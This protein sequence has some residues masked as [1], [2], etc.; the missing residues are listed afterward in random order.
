M[1]MNCFSNFDL[2]YE[3][4]VSG[5]YRKPIR[6]KLGLSFYECRQIQMSN[7]DREIIQRVLDG[8]VR[9]F[10]ILVDEH[11]AKAMTLAIRILKNREDAEEALQDAFIRVY[12]ALSSF[13]WKSSFAT[14]LYRIVYNTCAT[15][16]GK[17][18]GKYFLS[19][20][21]GEEDVPRM[22]I[23]SDEL[24]PD[25]RMESE[26]FSKIVSEEVEK[27]PS[28]YGSTFTLFTLQ[29]MSYEEIVQ[30]TGLPLGTIKARL[31]RARAMLREAVVKRMDH[32]L[33]IKGY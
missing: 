12:R 1:L 22:E 20:D 23:E 9:S 32:A 26:E 2:K 27:L 30:I 4:K 17:K 16:A 8:D 33:V 13:E 11:K 14:W 15:A 29:E 18:S 25:M 3:E 10:G 5:K 7:R 31:F 21:A 28:V 19:L 6:R 24:Q